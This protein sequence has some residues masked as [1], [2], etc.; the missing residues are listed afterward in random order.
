MKLVKLLFAAVLVPALVAPS[1]SAAAVRPA[2]KPVLAPAKQDRS[3]VTRS[4]ARAGA[5]LEQEN[6]VFLAALGPL[7]I[8][9]SVVAAIAVAAAVAAIVDDGE[10]SPG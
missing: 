8:A 2:V 5:K 10:V 9:A 6:N 7:L 3:L 1:V 4:S